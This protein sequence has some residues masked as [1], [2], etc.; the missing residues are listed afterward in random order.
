[1][2]KHLLWFTLRVNPLLY[3]PTP[4]DQTLLTLCWI[5][6]SLVS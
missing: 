1:M 2:L 3:E 4:P 6:L 5:S